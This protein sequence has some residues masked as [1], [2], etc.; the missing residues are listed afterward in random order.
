MK[1]LSFLFAAVVAV[2]FASCGSKSNEQAADEQT[3]VTVEQQEA[4]EGETCGKCKTCECEP[5]ECNKQ[6]AANCEEGAECPEAQEEAEAPAE[7]E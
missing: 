5:C 7:N 1:K 2:S 4:T 3:D 6:D